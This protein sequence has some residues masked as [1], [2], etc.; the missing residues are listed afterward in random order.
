MRRR[1]PDIVFAVAWGEEESEKMWGYNLEH[2]NQIY[3]CAWSPQREMKDFC[4]AAIREVPFM[5]RNFKWHEPEHI[6]FSLK[7]TGKVLKDR[8]ISEVV[9]DVQKALFA[10][11]GRE[12]A[13]RREVVRLHEIYEI[14]Q[15]TGH[16]VKD[17][18]ASFEVEV[19]GQHKAQRIYQM[20][21]I[22]MMATRITLE[23]VEE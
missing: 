13:T 10:A 8:I 4:M 12:S 22:D 2:I 7:I 21:S 23:Y 18:G 15:S 11:Y 9:E 19:A 16:F 14:I 17:T 6:T 3:I 1:F 5:C 20:V